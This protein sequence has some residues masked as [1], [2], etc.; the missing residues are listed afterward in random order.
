M[1]AVSDGDDKDDRKDDADRSSA[2]GGFRRIGMSWSG[3]R[4]NDVGVHSINCF[5]GLH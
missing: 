3:V 2:A 5:M 4:W 1:D